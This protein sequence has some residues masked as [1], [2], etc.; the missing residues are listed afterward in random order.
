MIDKI[1][2]S[3]AIVISVFALVFTC[4]T[5]SSDLYA[6]IDEQK[7]EAQ[8]PVPVLETQQ[9]KKAA[10]WCVEKSHRDYRD[11]V[12]EIEPESPVSISIDDQH[13]LCEFKRDARLESCRD[14][15]EARRSM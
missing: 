3:F 4:W 11:C 13:K 8:Q 6:E 1:L 5:K 2:S 7:R 15:R 10:E 14:E 9:Q 12:E